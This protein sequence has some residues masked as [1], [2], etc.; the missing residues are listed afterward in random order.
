MKSTTL[1]KQIGGAILG[2]TLLVGIGLISGSTA[3][4]QWQQWPSNRDYGQ[5]G[6]YG[7]NRGYGGFQVARERGYQAGL[8]TGQND[9]QRGQNF[10]PQRSH[11]YRNATDGYDRYYG[12]R[13]AYKQAYREAFVR[14]Y[15]DGFRRYRGN[16]RGNNGNNGRWRSGRWYPW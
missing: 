15:E 3:Q 10:N 13:D 6:D 8:S 9:S 5:N 1:M 2:L 14:G 12:N 11:Y 16:N 4:A 7:R